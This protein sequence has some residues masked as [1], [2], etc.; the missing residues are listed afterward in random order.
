MKRRLFS[1]GA[2]AAFSLFVV[3]NAET[4]KRASGSAGERSG[5]GS[6]RSA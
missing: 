4:R 2:L 6:S 1:L 3:S 5:D